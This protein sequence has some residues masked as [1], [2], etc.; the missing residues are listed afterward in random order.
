MEQW[1]RAT[2]WVKRNSRDLLWTKYSICSKYT[3][4][5]C[6]VYCGQQIQVEN[7]ME[8]GDVVKRRS[9]KAMGGAYLRPPRVVTGVL[10]GYECCDRAGNGERKRV[11]ALGW[12]LVSDSVCDVSAVW[13]T[14]GSP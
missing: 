11:G 13:C 6:C 3:P 7:E 14:L 10:E 9:L 1:H 5:C 12:T 8:C 4:R 2:K